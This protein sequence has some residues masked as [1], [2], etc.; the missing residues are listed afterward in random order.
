MR[1]HA[2]AINIGNQ[3]YRA[4]HR[5]GKAH[6]GDIIFT[7][8]NFSRAARAFD[9]HHIIL[10]LQTLKG[11]E[12]GLTRDRFVVVVSH[13]IHIANRMTLNNHLRTDVSIRFEQHRVHI[14]M[15]LNTGGLRLQSLRAANLPAVDSYRRIERHVLR[16]ERRDANTPPRQ[17]STQRGD[18]HAFTG[19][20]G[21]ALNHQHAHQATTS[22]RGHNSSSSPARA[23]SSRRHCVSFAGKP[24]RRLDGSLN[25]RTRMPCCASC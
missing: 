15:R 16:L 7:Q 21:C 13:R 24:N 20:R 25:R 2:T 17:T 19:I 10:L 8:I 14:C 23:D 3:Q 9:Q 22:S 6:I 11:F 12:H 4:V 5:F 1:K 18:Q